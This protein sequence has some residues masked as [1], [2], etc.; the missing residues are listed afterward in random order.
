MRAARRF[1]PFALPLLAL[2]WVPTLALVGL[3]WAADETVAAQ[4]RAPITVT[5]LYTGEDGKTHA[6]DI[7]VP[8]GAPRGATDRSTA[9]EVSSLQF[10]RTSPDYFLDWHNAPRRQYVVTLSGQSEVEIADGQTIRLYPGRVLLVE[11][12][13]G[14]GHVSRA[15]PGEER[16]SLFIPLAEP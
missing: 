4:G 12:V 14:Q 2:G 3:H 13:T 16:V 8:M 9:M 5:R 1:M 11:D 15:V 7:E 6:E 10:V